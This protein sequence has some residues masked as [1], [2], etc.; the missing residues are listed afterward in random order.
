MNI[1]IEQQRVAIFSFGR[2]DDIHALP[3]TDAVSVLGFLEKEM[4]HEQ[5]DNAINERLVVP[6][7]SHE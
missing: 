6:F 4:I 5:I 3:G 7:K 1:Y 2:E